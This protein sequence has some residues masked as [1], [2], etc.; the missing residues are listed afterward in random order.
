MDWGPKSL[1]QWICREWVGKLGFNEL[2][3]H[4]S[5][6]KWQEDIN[7]QVYNE[8]NRH[9]Q[10]PRRSVL[11]YIFFFSDLITKSILDTTVVF[12]F[13]FWSP[14]L[15]APFFFYTVFPFHFHL[16]RA[17]VL[18]TLPISRH[19]LAIRLKSTVHVSLPH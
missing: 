17:C 6:F 9:R 18:S 1:K 16:P 12:S 5:R 3:K 10:N 13:L 19:V 15:I 4:K 8:E 14:C 11:I 7:G 2:D